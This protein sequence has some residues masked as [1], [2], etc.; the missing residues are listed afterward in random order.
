M[1]VICALA[2]VVCMLRLKAD[3]S[4]DLLNIENIPQVQKGVPKDIN[5]Y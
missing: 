4:L 2:S 5:S 3:K 1:K